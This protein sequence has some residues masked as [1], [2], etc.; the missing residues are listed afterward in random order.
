MN[1][2]DTT[3]RLIDRAT[4]ACLSA[5]PSRETVQRL[6]AMSHAAL[7]TSG[8]LVFSVPDCGCEQGELCGDPEFCDL[9][10]AW[11]ATFGAA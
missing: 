5:S 1:R 4:D 7:K 11:D 8:R 9:A 10:R 3:A 2:L 6:L